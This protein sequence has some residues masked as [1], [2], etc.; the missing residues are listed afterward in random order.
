[1]DESERTVK[2]AAGA[3]GGAAA[4]G[5]FGA[6]I[7]AIGGAFQFGIPLG[8][9]VGIV[10][11]FTGQGFPDF[12]AALITTTVVIGAIFGI[13]GGIFYALMDGVGVSQWGKK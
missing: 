11:V 9:I 13:I 1:M 7:G 3:V 8:L 2:G 5:L 4:G 12:L 6:V 10:A